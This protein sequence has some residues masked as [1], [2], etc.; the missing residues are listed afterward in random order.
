MNFGEALDELLRSRET[1]VP[2]V[3][4]RSV[5]DPDIEISIGED[6]RE[7]FGVFLKKTCGSGLSIKFYPDQEGLFAEDWEVVV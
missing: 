5:W 6:E 4:R 7:K 3:I 2:V 1:N